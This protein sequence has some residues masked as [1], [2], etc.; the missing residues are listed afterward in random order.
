MTAPKVADGAA[1]GIP[2]GPA[3]ARRPFALTPLAD[4][5]FQL[6]IFFMLSSSL[7][8]YALLPMGAPATADPGPAAE[9][10]AGAGAA[11][12]QVVWHLGRGTVRAGDSRIALENLPSALTELRADQIVE[13]VVFVTDAAQAQDLADL[14]EPVRRAG[15][16]RL[17]LIGG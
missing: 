17:Q 16:V 11:T 6:L 3:R 8:P 2:P 15:F 10:A 5:M 13:I 12:E 4:V 9:A 14:I 1:G 7:A